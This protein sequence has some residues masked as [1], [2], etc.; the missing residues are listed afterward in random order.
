MPLVSFLCRAGQASEHTKI[1]SDMLNK[2]P[3]PAMPTRQASASTD[4]SGSKIDA[5]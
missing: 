5:V 2:Y 4:E 1:S 3:M